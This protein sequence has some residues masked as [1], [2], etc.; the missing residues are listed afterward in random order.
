MTSP[1]FSGTHLWALFPTWAIPRCSSI[2]KSP[3]RSRSM[4]FEQIRTV[5]LLSNTSML[6]LQ[7]TYVNKLTT[8]SL[9]QKS[10]INSS[11]V[12]KIK[13]MYWLNYRIV[14]GSQR[15]TRICKLSFNLSQ[16]SS[17]CLNYKLYIQNKMK[18]KLQ[19][20][21]L[22]YACF[23]PEEKTTRSV[24]KNKDRFAKLKNYFQLFI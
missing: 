22:N 9:N 12:S 20:K 23:K 16:I 14:T 1:H 10:F 21:A 5:R 8:L 2:H 4:T 13:C 19:M 3:S 17:W 11:T 24:K 18:N 15:K 7:K 6:H